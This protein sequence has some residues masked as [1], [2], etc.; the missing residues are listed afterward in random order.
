[1]NKK[2]TLLLRALMLQNF[3]HERYDKASSELEERLQDQTKAYN[4]SQ[5]L[6]HS[7]QHDK[8]WEKSQTD[9][10]KKVSKLIDK[11]VSSANIY[12]KLA[13]EHVLF[14]TAL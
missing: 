11:A 14:Y 9:L 13:K 5:R 3:E 1:M 4:K 8:K 2:G 12:F 10:E 6:L 7:L